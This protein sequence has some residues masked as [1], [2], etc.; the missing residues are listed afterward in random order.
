VLPPPNA[1]T[2]AS[3]S[4]GSPATGDG[5][6]SGSSSGG[7]SA[8]GARDLFDPFTFV[9]NCPNPEHTWIDGECRDAYV[10]P[11]ALP[12][13]REDLVGGSDPR[14]GC[15]DVAGCFAR[16]TP[17]G[18][19]SAR[20]QALTL[21]AARCSVRLNGADPA[22]LN[23]AV[24][25]PD[26]GECL[27]PGECYVPLDHGGAGW[28]A[29]GGEIK[30]P[31]FVCRLLERKKLALAASADCAPKTESRAL[32]IAPAPGGP[33]APA[34]DAAADAVA[35]PVPFT[36]GVYA[37]VCVTVLANRDPAQAFRF[38]TDA[39]YSAV[40]GG[41]GGTLSLSITPLRGWDTAA[42][43]SY[44]PAAV[45]RIETRGA[46]VAATDVRVAG[47]GRFTAAFGRLDL[48]AEANSVSG[49]AAVIEDLVLDGVFSGSDRFC[50]GFA[51]NM[52]VPYHYPFEAGKN[53]CLFQK[54]TEGGPLPVLA[55][56]EFVCTF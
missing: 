33:S 37:G 11:A 16:S 46:A 39:R 24:V 18:A 41:E 2:S 55:A 26:T 50:S 52:T 9:P 12:D 47:G 40:P 43:A 13:F 45:S 19:E 15:F 28:L 44:T 29:E 21:D 49:R 8:P 25:T 14:G 30:L 17:V 7:A 27:R 3:S 5:G 51:G 4:S 48:E 35:E 22:R 53:T 31:A 36:D 32:C 34:R 56:A 38:Y 1:G 42:N 23:L 20:P 54:V 6:S 10:D